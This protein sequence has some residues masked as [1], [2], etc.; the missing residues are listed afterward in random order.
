MLIPC[1]VYWKVYDMQVHFLILFW[2][3]S[4]WM[5]KK[6]HALTDNALK[7]YNV[8]IFEMKTAPDIM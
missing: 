6:N 3:F 4:D 5:R 2:L 1:I 7:G 8:C